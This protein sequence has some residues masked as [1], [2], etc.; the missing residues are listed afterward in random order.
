MLRD[1]SMASA[2]R[3]ATCSAARAN[4]TW[5]GTNW[6]RTSAAKL[7]RYRVIRITTALPAGGL[8]LNSGAT[9]SSAGPKDRSRSWHAHINRC[10]AP[11]RRSRGDL[12]DQLLDHGA[13]EGA[14]IF[15]HHHE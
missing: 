5:A 9:M 14:E 4:G 3:R 12:G 11:R 7:N 2:S 6:V 8:S 10:S 1:T 13:A 15:R